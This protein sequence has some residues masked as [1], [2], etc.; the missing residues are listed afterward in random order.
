M[1]KHTNVRVTDPKNYNISTVMSLS[2][3]LSPDASGVSYLITW[4]VILSHDTPVCRLPVLDLM[5][6]FVITHGQCSLFIS[7]A[8]IFIKLVCVRQ[9]KCYTKSTRIKAC[10]GTNILA[11]IKRTQS[12]VKDQ[13]R[14]T[15]TQQRT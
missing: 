5:L 7:L 11:E 1:I 14:K 3:V 13:T 9:S 6:Y 2:R 15:D 4:S 12:R 8:Y 10:K